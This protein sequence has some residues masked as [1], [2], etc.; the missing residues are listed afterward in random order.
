MPLRRGIPIRRSHTR[1]HHTRYGDR[2]HTAQIGHRLRHRDSRKLPLPEGFVP[3]EEQL[4][5]V[6]ALGDEEEDDKEDSDSSGEGEA[7]GDA[8]QDETGL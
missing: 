1:D 3:N 5:A 2:A 4:A 7:S 6:A 8:D